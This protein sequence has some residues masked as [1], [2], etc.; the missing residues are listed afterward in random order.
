MSDDWFWPVFELCNF[1][2][3]IQTNV[4]I[5]IEFQVLEN[6]ALFFLDTYNKI[7]TDEMLMNLLQLIKPV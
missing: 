4:V 6:G 5:V 3:I 1:G 2:E 7:S